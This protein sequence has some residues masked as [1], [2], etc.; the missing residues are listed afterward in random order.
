MSR[1]AA[2]DKLQGLLAGCRRAGLL[3]AHE[4]TI[5]A[6]QG[7]ASDREFFR[8][9]QG[10]QRYIALLSPRKNL[11]GID[12]NDS[13]F[14][15][16]RHLCSHRLPAPRILWSDLE[17]GRFLLEDLGDCHLQTQIVTRRTDIYRAYRSAIKLLTR[18]HRLAPEGFQ[19]H[20]CFDTADYSPDFVYARELQYFR[21][22]FL[23]GYLQLEVAEEDLRS[24]FQA[25]AEAAGSDRR[26]QV[27]HRDFQSRN[28]MVWQNRLWLLDFQG[29]RFGPPAYDLAS[30]LIDPYVALPRR[31]QEY[32]CRYYWTGAAAFLG[33]SY[34]QFLSTYQAV[35]LCRNLQVLA[36]YAFLGTVKGKPQFLRYIPTAWRFLDD[37]SRGTQSRRYPKLQGIV[38]AIR[39]L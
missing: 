10:A 8:L 27:M 3:E 7:D 19:S 17:E 28:L 24:D 11:N 26:L 15:I 6:L 32:L 37:W 25:L 1:Q 30:L 4:P 16:G 23:N 14:L 38:F 9:R 36:A 35:K 33:G 5:T 29:M 2:A 31:L 21:N 13:Y 39:R 22:A 18:V 34:Q 20:F 12:E